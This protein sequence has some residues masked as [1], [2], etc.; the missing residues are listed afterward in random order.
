MPFP[1]TF[2][3]R[4]RAA[5]VTLIRP[6]SLNSITEELLADLAAVLDDLEADTETRVAVITGTGRSGRCE[7][8][9]ELETCHTWQV[10]NDVF[11][12]VAFGPM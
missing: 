12:V 7:R 9:N 4:N 5:Y 1:L 3:K 8:R 10:R 6:H 11:S 2:E